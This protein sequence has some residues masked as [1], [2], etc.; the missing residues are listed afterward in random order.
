VLLPTVN[1]WM[2]TGGT[3]LVWLVVEVASGKGHALTAFI[4][5]RNLAHDFAYS[6][7]QTLACP[8]WRNDM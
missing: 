2:L 1:D 4:N 6:M 5:A 7:H 8:G 3:N